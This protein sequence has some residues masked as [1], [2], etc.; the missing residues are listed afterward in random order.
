MPTALITHDDCLKHITPPGHPEQVARL[1]C[2][3]NALKSVDLMRVEAKLATKEEIS[4]LHPAVYIDGIEKAIPDCGWESLD[5][6]T[7]LSPGSFAAALRA[8]GGVLE[9][10][11]SLYLVVLED[12]V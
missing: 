6:D 12:D 9:A 7:H 10:V 2:I 3:I 11:V 1:E 5:A 4:L 8:V